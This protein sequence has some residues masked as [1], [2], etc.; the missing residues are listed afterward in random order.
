MRTPAFENRDV[1]AL[2]DASGERRV[3]AF[4]KTQHAVVPLPERGEIVVGRSRECAL[5]I[6]IPSL[7]RRHARLLVDQ[8]DLAVEDLGS[9][10]GTY[11]AGRKLAPNERVVVEPGTAIAVGGALLLLVAPRRGDTAEATG[12]TTQAT[13][14]QATV[15]QG[16][17]DDAPVPTDAPLPPPRVEATPMNGVHQLV[18]LVA[19]SKLSVILLGE[20]GVGKEVT[21]ARV[22]A[23]SLRA[24]KPFAQINCAA[25]SDTLL[26]SELFGHEKG[27]FT[28]AVAAKAGIFEAADGGTVFLD[29]LGEMS[30]TMQAKLLRA[31][32]TGGVTRVGGL[33][34][35]HVDVRFVAATHRDLDAMV[36]EGR[37]REDLFFR[38]NGLTIVIPPLRERRAEVLPFAQAFLVDA[39][40]RAGRAT[41]RLG[42]EAQAKLL[43]HSWPGNVREL[44]NVMARAAVLA[45]GDVVGPEH[46]LYGRSSALTPPPPSVAAAPAAAP[47]EDEDDTERRRIQ[48][49]LDQCGGNQKEAAARL[50]ISRRTLLNR[51]DAYKLPRPRKR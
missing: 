49:A 15:I 44:K 20:T 24:D 35:R 23:Q 39:S 17:A 48:E 30:L 9:S 45:T 36:T 19:R 29:E 33:K 21:A 51:L 42:P 18:D 27:A 13:A 12:T 41:P 1:R 3:V 5:R 32:E 38:L 6:D 47:A 28:G 7:S 31:V 22:H 8:D 46:I 16:G 11:V 50:G 4:Y 25:L 14:T 2:L 34:P 26:E 43:E 37:F 10:N 40:A